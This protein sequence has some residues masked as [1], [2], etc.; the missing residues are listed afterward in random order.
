MIRPPPRSTLFPYTTLFRSRR[1]P[2]LPRRI[3]ALEPQRP[4]TPPSD[5][6]RGELDQPSPPIVVAD[7][8]V[9]RSVPEP[10]RV[11]R[12]LRTRR[13][14]LLGRPRE[15]RRRD[16]DRFLEKRAVQ[17]VG[18]VE[19][20]EHP[21]RGLRHEPFHRDLPPRPEFLDEIGRA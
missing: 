16:V 1:P 5:G 6:P 17:R 9:D 20:R 3:P 2:H 8:R 12:R 21:Q 19:D 18:L 13:D 15:A 11:D 4:A 14:F 10:E 7:F